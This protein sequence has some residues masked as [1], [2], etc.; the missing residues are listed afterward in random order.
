MRIVHQKMIA[1]IRAGKAGSA[2]SNTTVSPGTDDKGRP[3]MDVYLHGHHIVRVHEELPKEGRPVSFTLA[4]YPT[5]T[6]R[7]RV[8]AVLR[9]FQPGSYVSQRKGLQYAACPRFGV[10]D[11]AEREISSTEWVRA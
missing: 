7:A 9:E 11:G 3:C 5:A 6:T 8:V 10:R 2:G 4:G 1:L